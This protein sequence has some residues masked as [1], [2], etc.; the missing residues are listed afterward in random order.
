MGQMKRMVEDQEAAL[1]VAADILVEAEYFEPCRHGELVGLH[2]WAEQKSHAMALATNYAKK[3]PEFKREKLLDAVDQ[4]IR[5][6]GFCA[7]CDNDLDDDDDD[8]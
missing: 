3:H 5:N 6:N 8:E 1:A 7:L 4:A 2:P